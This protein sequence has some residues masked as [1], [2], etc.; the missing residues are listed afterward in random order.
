MKKIYILLICIFG[1]SDNI[2]NE[3]TKNIPNTSKPI[4]KKDNVYG[5]AHSQAWYG[6]GLHLTPIVTG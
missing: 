4:S 5:E 3:Q 6:A 2:N 1:C